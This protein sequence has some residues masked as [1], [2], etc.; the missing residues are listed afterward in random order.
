[1]KMRVY[2]HTAKS[3]EHRAP[4]AKLGIGHCRYALV[5]IFIESDSTDICNQK[6]CVK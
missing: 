6:Y 2:I 3:I 4:C 5:N 1:M